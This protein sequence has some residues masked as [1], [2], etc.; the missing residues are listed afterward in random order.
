M[1][2]TNDK[3]DKASKI[4][5]YLH[6]YGLPPLT[7]DQQTELDTPITVEEIVS[8]IKA[9]PNGKSPGPDGYTKAYYKKFSQILVSQMCKYFNSLTRGNCIPPEALLAHI[10]V[11]PKEGKDPTTPQSYRPIS[12][13]NTDV[14]ILAKILANRLKHLIPQVV[15]LDQTGFITGRE[16]RDN[17]IRAIQLIHW[18][19]RQ[20]NLPPYL[21]LSTD[22]ETASI[23][24]TCVQFSLHGV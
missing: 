4:Q 13:L 6:S 23:G 20:E 9:L 16:A 12:L 22:A 24:P 8:T 7:E 18:A 15:H 17:S 3:A 21:I 19:R 1:T 5:E 10:S 14:K 2:I 11:I